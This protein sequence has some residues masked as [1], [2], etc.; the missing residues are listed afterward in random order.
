MIFANEPATVQRRARLWI[1]SVLFLLLIAVSCSTAYAEET[2]EATDITVQCSFD[3][4]AGKN[5]FICDQKYS[6][7]WKSVKRDGIHALMIA[8]PENESI[9]GL[10]IRWGDAPQAAE[11]QTQNADGTWTT[12]AQCNA[13]FYAQYIAVPTLKECRV[14]ASGDTQQQLQIADITVLTPGRLPKDIQVWG[15]VGDKVDMMVV[16]AHPDDEVLWFGGLIPY[17]AGERGKRVLVVC[18]T[19]K[20][21]YRR[22]ELL[23]CLWTCG[24]RIEPV[25]CDLPDYVGKSFEWLL[26]AWDYDALLERYTALY[27]QYKPNVVVL[28]DIKGES[29]HNGHRAMSKVGRECAPLAAD[30]TKYPESVQ[31]YGIWNVPKVYVHLYDENVIRMDW[32]S[33]LAAFGGMSAQDVARLGFAKQ[34]SQTVNHKLKDGGL[35]DNALFGLY[36]TQVGLDVAKNDL[37]EHIP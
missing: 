18:A 2:A 28:Q 21:A 15:K 7:I 4:R 27:R 37:F 13:E 31:T 11:V 9:G 23:D 24:D 22:L 35:Y 30:P 14:V 32:N 26:D 19:T 10:L 17:Y 25:F 1:A 5:Q 33:P 16:T 6:T 8:A 20:H 36:R 29:G 12:V 34:V 3:G